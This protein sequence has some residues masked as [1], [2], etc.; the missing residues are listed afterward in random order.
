M[1]KSAKG[2][3][4]RVVRSSKG[5]AR[6]QRRHRQKGKP[7]GRAAVVLKKKKAEGQKAK[8]RRERPKLLYRDHRRVYAF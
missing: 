4:G 6:A 7:G 2:G 1:S 3:H 5:G 8:G